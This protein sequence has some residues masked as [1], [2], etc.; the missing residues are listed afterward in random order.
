[1]AEI[2]LHAA[3]LKLPRMVALLSRSTA[4]FPQMEAM[5]PQTFAMPPEEG[6]NCTGKLES[7]LKFSNF[8]SDK[9]HQ[10]RMK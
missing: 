5:L 9:A 4:V 2:L 3:K 8:V 10:V 6:L 7:P 1:M